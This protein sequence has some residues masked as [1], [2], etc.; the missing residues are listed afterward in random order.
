L[1]APARF[2]RLIFF[3][4]CLVRWLK[5]YL[6]PAAGNLPLGKCRCKAPVLDLNKEIENYGG[7]V[8]AHI[9][10]LKFVYLGVAISTLVPEAKIVRKIGAPFGS[11]AS[12]AVGG[13]IKCRAITIYNQTLNDFIASIGMG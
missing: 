8:G 12:G 4:C 9:R 5:N 13:G 10:V 11:T 1:C 3:E 2:V 7:R 6:K